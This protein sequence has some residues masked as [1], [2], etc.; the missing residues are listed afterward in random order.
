M[1]DSKILFLTDTTATEVDDDCGMRFWLEHLECG[2]G[3]MRKDEVVP[4]IIED[5]FHND[6]RT[7]STMEDITPSNLQAAVDE[8]LNHLTPQ[9]R[10]DVKKMELLYRRLGWF[11]AFGLFMEPKI[12]EMFETIPLPEQ[13][14][15]DRDPLFVL[16]RPDRLLQNKNN[17]MLLYREY[18]IVPAGVTD[19]SWSTC[20]QYK[21][22]LHTSMAAISEH[23]KLSNGPGCALLT[24]VGMGTMM[25]LNAGFI[26]S[27]DKRL[28]H[29]YVWAYKHGDSD[30]WSMNK[31]GRDGEAVGVPVWDYPLGLVDWVS[32][33]GE[34]TALAQ[35]R[36]SDTVRLSHFSLNEWIS[37][38]THRERQVREMRAQCTTNRHLRAVHFERRTK[39]CRPLYGKSCPMLEACW[40]ADLQTQPCHSGEYVTKDSPLLNLLIN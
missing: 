1:T 7:L 31:Y 9:D 35:F 11:V 22:H 16:T 10:K 3:I 38:R 13:I 17:R 5:A 8:I 24:P 19:T 39:M 2:H 34:S 27:V 30:R 32:H 25:G 40:R 28:V 4:Q 29:P 15:L 12:R 14:V 21:P 36:F 6:L 33:C 37:R 23:L 26:S 18:N 20:W